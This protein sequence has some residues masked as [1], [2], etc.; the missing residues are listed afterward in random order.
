MRRVAGRAAGLTGEVGGAAF[1]V[2]GVGERCFI[3]DS[4]AGWR[5]KMKR[6][7]RDGEIFLPIAKAKFCLHIACFANH[8]ADEPTGSVGLEYHLAQQVAVS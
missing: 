1:L 3:H 2:H 7:F 5:R 4:H 6:R 8:H